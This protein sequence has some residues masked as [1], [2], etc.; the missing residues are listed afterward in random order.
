MHVVDHQAESPV[1]VPPRNVLTESARI[2]RGNVRSI[3]T[4]KASELDALIIPGGFGAAKNLCDFAV[5]GADMDVHT[6]VERLIRDMHS[7]GK[8][9]GFI[10][11][12][13]AIAAKVLGADHQVQVTIGTDPDTASS[14]Q[15]MGAQHVDVLPGGIHIDENN[16]VVSTPAYML[17]PDIASVHKGI[18][19]LVESVLARVR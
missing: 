12:A 13:P 5:K 11:I 14:L 16:C 2:S 17:G 9:Q 4:V 19:A 15:S 3:E 10:C 18:D 6:E 8:P 1:D 7:A